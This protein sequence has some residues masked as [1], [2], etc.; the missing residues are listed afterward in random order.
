[1]FYSENENKDPV[2]IE[3]INGSNQ[4]PIVFNAQSNIKTLLGDSTTNSLGRNEIEDL[5]FSSQRETF[6]C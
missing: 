5:F 2:I 4:F 1:M 6:S 3:K